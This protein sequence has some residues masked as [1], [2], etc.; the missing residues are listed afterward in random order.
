MIGSH[1]DSVADAGRYDGILGILV[2][3]EV[4]E[5]L[6]DAPL[7]VVAFADE[8]G[9]RFQSIYLGSRALRRRA[10]AGRAGLRD[11]RRR[12]AARGDR[13]P[14][15]A[16]P[17]LRPGDARLPRGPHRA[18]P[19][20]RGRGSAARRRHR[21]RRPEPLQPRLRGPR[22]P[23]RD[24]AD[25]PA[26][27]RRRRGRRVRARRRARRARRAGAGRDGRRA[28]RPARRGQR[29]PGPRGRDARHPPPG[30]RACAR[31]RPRRCGRV[32]AE[33]AAAAGVAVAWSTISAPAARRACTPAL[34][35][36][37]ADAVR[38]PAS[39]GARAAER[40]RPRRGDDGRA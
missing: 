16:A 19:G 24:D 31:R 13:R 10:R 32:T 33:I 9:L 40:R 29:D 1:L 34:V 11:A 28:Q 4:A 35:E 7:E 22:R 38:R 21:D 23:R 3:L 39:T 37:V 8:D 17:L 26:P 25:A 2:G 27:R 20:A 5:A 18:G 15:P 12:D 36:R 14:S 6:P 30:R